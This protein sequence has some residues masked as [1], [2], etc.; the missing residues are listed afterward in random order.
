MELH[1]RKHLINEQ[2]QKKFEEVVFTFLFFRHTDQSWFLS[3]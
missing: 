1:L 2:F 3:Q